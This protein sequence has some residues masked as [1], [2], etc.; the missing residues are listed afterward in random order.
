MMGAFERKLVNSYI[1]KK[2]PNYK[3]S[4]YVIKDDTMVI[5]CRDKYYKLYDVS[6]TLDELIDNYK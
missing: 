6:V 4:F 1:D 5:T 2:Y 3:W